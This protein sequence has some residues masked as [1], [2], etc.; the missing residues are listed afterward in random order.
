[1]CVRREDV[2]ICVSS[3][4]KCKIH[5]HLRVSVEEHLHYATVSLKCNFAFALHLLEIALVGLLST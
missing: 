1:M 4:L 5:S 3:L 2:H